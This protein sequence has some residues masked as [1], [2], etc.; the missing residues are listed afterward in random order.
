MAAGNK[1]YINVALIDNNF[2]GWYGDFETGYNIILK[3]QDD[4]PKDS[5]VAASD[6]SVEFVINGG[7]LKAGW[8]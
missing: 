7:M 1:Q 8:L 5:Y 2:S 4:V 3:N 6:K